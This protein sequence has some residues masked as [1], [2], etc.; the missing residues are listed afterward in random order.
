MEYSTEIAVEGMSCQHC[1][2]AVKEALEA[3][4][5]VRRADVELEPGR[6]RLT[7]DQEVP[8]EDLAAAVREEGYDA[9]QS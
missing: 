3:I 6:A 9:R 1:V 5:G 2:R 4:P 8:F 7:M